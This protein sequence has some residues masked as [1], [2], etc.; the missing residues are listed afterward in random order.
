[1]NIIWH[2]GLQIM[3]F[4]KDYIGDRCKTLCHIELSCTTSH[5]NNMIRREISS[6]QMG[7]KSIKFDLK[8]LV[9]MK[10]N[11]NEILLNFKIWQCIVILIKAYG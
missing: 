7:K 9:S 4:V 3:C 6:V 5:F 8:N 2:F 10:T 1:M 11:G